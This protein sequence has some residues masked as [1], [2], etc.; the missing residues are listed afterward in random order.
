MN[1][2]RRRLGARASRP[3]SCRCG[4]DARAPR[5]IMR[6]WCSPARE[7]RDRGALQRQTLPALTRRA[8]LMRSCRALVAMLLGMVGIHVAAADQAIRAILIGPDAKA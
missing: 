8:T 2:L 7:C 1:V 6:L 5:F 3:L 4:R